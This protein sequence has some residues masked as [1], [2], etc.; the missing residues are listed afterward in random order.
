MT[1]LPSPVQAE[2]KRQ[3]APITAQ[4]C[5]VANQRQKRSNRDIH[6]GRRKLPPYL[7]NKA[8]TFES[9]QNAMSRPARSYNS[10]V[11]TAQDHTSSL[12]DH[13]QFQSSGLV[14]FQVRMPSSQ[15][16]SRSTPAKATCNAHHHRFCT[17]TVK[18]REVGI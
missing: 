11:S 1:H 17:C 7:S 16:G 10:S 8:H 12:L 9:N 18:N 14:P 6:A 4:C 15:G 3:Y 13:T 2:A 5:Y